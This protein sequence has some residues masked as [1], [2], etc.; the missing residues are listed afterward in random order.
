[1]RTAVGYT[2]NIT[3][4]THPITTNAAAIRPQRQVV[5]R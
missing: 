2:T 5:N 3:F 4:I 1:M